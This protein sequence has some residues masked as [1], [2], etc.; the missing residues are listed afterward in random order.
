MTNIY[1]NFHILFHKCVQFVANVRV[2]T[3][4]LLYILGW[5]RFMRKE[6]LKGKK[7]LLWLY[8]AVESVG[9]QTVRKSWMSTKHKTRNI[10]S[11]IYFM[12]V[13]K[14]F[15]T[16]TV[17]R[18]TKTT[19]TQLCFRHFLIQWFWSI[20]ARSYQWSL[21]F[22]TAAQC[23]IKEEYKQSLFTRIWDGLVYKMIPLFSK[24]LFLEKDFLKMRNILV[25][26][27]L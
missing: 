27:L 14:A 13:R 11:H 8:I 3:P 15:E 10:L 16:H 19:H 9:S 20:T 4:I 26:I 24:H 1:G 12:L 23:Q 21:Y 2:T 7:Q 5:T 6:E 25:L 18:V 22:Q 17:G